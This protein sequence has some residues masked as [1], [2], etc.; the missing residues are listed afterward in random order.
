M[1]EALQIKLF[2]RGLKAIEILSYEEFL[3]IIVLYLY[4]YFLVE[5]KNIDINKEL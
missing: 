5:N 1:R 4:Q 2:S 3:V